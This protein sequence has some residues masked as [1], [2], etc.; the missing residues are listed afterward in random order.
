MECTRFGIWKLVANIKGWN[1]QDRIQALFGFSPSGKSSAQCYCPL[2]FSR[3]AWF[4]VRWNLG[5]G[6][7]GRQM[8]ISSPLP[9]YT[10]TE[11][12]ITPQHYDLPLQIFWLSAGS[13]TDYSAEVSGSPGDVREFGIREFWKKKNKNR[14][15]QST[16]SNPP[17]S[18]M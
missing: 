12:Q 3:I 4:E 8:D 7:A 16:H 10:T 15:R 6:W 11:C 2:K 18:K 13:E 1:L 5:G 17:D 9:W 14:N